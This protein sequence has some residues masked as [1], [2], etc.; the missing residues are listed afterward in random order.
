MVKTIDIEYI[1]SPF[2]LT[3]PIDKVYVIDNFL[4]SSLHLWVDDW[5]STNPIWGKTNRVNSKDPTGLPCHELWGASFFEGTDSNNNPKV[6]SDILYQH[7]YMPKWLNRKIQTDFGFMWE[8][9]QYMGTNSQTAYQHGTCHSDC[10]PEDNWGLSFLY[11][12]NKW[13]NPTWGGDLN[14]Y[15]ELKYGETGVSEWA[16][17]HR[18]GSVEFKPNRLIMFDGRIPHGANAPEPKAKWADRKSIVLR[19]DEIRLADSEEYFNANDRI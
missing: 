11:F 12:T 8:R 13:W 19:G 1:D 2:K 10:E 4:P 9:F 15:D 5:I 14:F 18:I 17:K 16:E 3:K 6:C 7:C